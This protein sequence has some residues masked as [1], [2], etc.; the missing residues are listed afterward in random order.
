MIPTKKRWYEKV[1]GKMTELNM[2]YSDLATRLSERGIETAKSTVGAWMI[3]RN[4]PP[5]A[6]I[7]EIGGLL[8]MSISE[9]VGEDKFFIR[10][11]VL[12][13]IVE[14]LDSMTEEER[15]AVLKFLTPQP[16]PPES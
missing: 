3:G 6:V 14:R 8:G 11:P 16:A 7:R 5:L 1:R 2:S 10:D 12:R 15:R 4:E 13:Q 9:I